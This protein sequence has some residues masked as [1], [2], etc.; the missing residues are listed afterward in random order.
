M[1]F[2]EIDKQETRPAHTEQV[3]FDPKVWEKLQALT[4]EKG[5][6]HHC[7][8]AILRLYFE[9]VPQS[10][11]QTAPSAANSGAKKPKETQIDGA[12]KAAA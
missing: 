4:S 12:K 11:Q 6:V 9:Q 2:I 1:P 5:D 8:N 3:N 10:K 7:V